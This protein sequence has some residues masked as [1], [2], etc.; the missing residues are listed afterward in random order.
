[1][2]VGDSDGRTG[3][4]T[5]TGEARDV[6]GAGVIDD[7]VECVDHEWMSPSGKALL[8]MSKTSED[9]DASL[10]FS[11][12]LSGEDASGNG[13]QNEDDTEGAFFTW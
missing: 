3:V 11:R 5:A 4:S 8:D 1:M 7:D 12:A 2:G 9:G 6:F 10:N 13:E